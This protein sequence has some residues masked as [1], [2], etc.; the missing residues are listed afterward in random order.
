MKNVW[1]HSMTKMTCLNMLLVYI[2]KKD[3]FYV[4][5][6]KDADRVHTSL[7]ISCQMADRLWLLDNAEL[8][9]L[10]FCNFTFQLL[11]VAPQF[12][13]KKVSLNL[14]EFL[15]NWEIR[16]TL[17]QTCTDPCTI[18]KTVQFWNL[19]FHLPPYKFGCYILLHFIFDN[20]LSF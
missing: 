9:A 14:S 1:N 4:I 2:L 19:K 12:L 3:C 11:Q 16:R 17:A 15:E 7:K 6:S 8:T 13:V 5:N 20:Y 18:W 10:R